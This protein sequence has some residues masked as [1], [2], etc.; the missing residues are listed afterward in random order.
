MFSVGA[1]LGISAWKAE[2]AE[3]IEG[4]KDAEILG[5]QV[6]IVKR[7]AGINRFVCTGTLI[8]PKWVLTAKSCTKSLGDSA[9]LVGD[10]R[11]KKGSRHKIISKI[12]NP[13]AD[14][15]LLQIQQRVPEEYAVN[16]APDRPQ[17]G[18]SLDDDPFS[19]QRSNSFL[20]QIRGWGTT[21]K[22]TGIFS[23]RP[24]T[25]QELE[26]STM[27][28]DSKE[29]SDKEAFI[30]EDFEKGGTIWDGDFGAGL[31]V[32]GK[33][34]GVVTGVINKD[35]G[36]RDIG[37]TMGS[38]IGSTM[39]SSKILGVTTGSV[40]PWIEQT[41]GVKP[42]MNLDER[43]ILRQGVRQTL[44][45]IKQRA[46]Q[47]RADQEARDKESG[48]ACAP[49]QR[50]S[51]LSTDLPES[52]QLDSSVF[53][54]PIS[55]ASVPCTGGE[56]QERSDQEARDTGSKS[57]PRVGAPAKAA[58]GAGAGIAGDAL[59]DFIGGV[60]ESQNTDKV[61]EE[62]RTK[63]SEQYPGYN[64]MVIQEETYDEPENI[65]GVQTNF[66][67]TIGGNVWDVWV[68]ES[69]TFTNEGD[70]GYN[71]W[72]FSGNFEL[73]GDDGETVTF[74]LEETEPEP[75]PLEGEEREDFL[76][77][78]DGPSGSAEHAKGL[79]RKLKE[80]YPGYNVMVIQQ[81]TY[82][83][84]ENLQGTLMTFPISPQFDQNPWDVWVFESGTFTNEGDLG[85][86]N[87]VFSGN[88]ERSG[89]DGETVT[90][91]S[92]EQ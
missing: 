91:E 81:E 12:P 51:V 68:F 39:G 87:W 32:D 47:E 59:E 35:I 65:Q 82:E 67:E 9:I 23:D 69:G 64:V 72:V 25:L 41:T 77:G 19:S 75:E 83:E 26:V 79:M 55:R 60:E 57:P 58:G 85:Y 34:Y 90:F 86:N 6:Q 13:N 45:Q 28:E 14:V 29:G 70:L 40:A 4:G 89:D 33:I 11:Y 31:Y 52:D 22:P 18:E 63:V 62:L 44:E 1:G 38:S 5:G 15:A 74:S 92:I 42:S 36:S 2:P 27:I 49:I 43:R 61:A 78:V 21:K 17:S 20:A 37:S 73:S 24:K 56:E 16:Y 76:K 3:A 50:T 80:R 53:A 54:A 30:A 46:D 84:P 66:T 8:D 10:T 71:N 7:T 88:F 48:N